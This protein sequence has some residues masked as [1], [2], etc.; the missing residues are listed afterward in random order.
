MWFRPVNKMTNPHDCK[1]QSSFKVQEF[2]DCFVLID[3]R[4][5][6]VPPDLEYS[7][8][9]PVLQIFL[10]FMEHDRSLLCS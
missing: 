5:F 1:A 3:V 4:C 2:L 6:Y 8:V 10:A 9:R 7:T